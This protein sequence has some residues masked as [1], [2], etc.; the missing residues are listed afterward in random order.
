MATFI[1]Y[2]NIGGQPIKVFGFSGM[3]DYAI[4]PNDEVQ[5]RVGDNETVKDVQYGRVILKGN[6]DEHVLPVAQLKDAALFSTA[7]E[8]SN[9]YTLNRC[10]YLS[11]W[12]AGD[13]T[14]NSYQPESEDAY[15]IGKDEKYHI[16]KGDKITLKLRKNKDTNFF[17][18]REDPISGVCYQVE[19]AA[20]ENAWI[21]VY[22][23][24]EFA[25]PVKNT[26]SDIGDLGI[27]GDFGYTA[28]D[29][30]DGYGTSAML[31]LPQV[32]NKVL[33]T[34]L[35]KIDVAPTAIPINPPLVGSVQKPLD[36][37]VVSPLLPKS[38]FAS[39]LTG[40]GS[41]DGVPTWAKMSYVGGIPLG[42]T[43]AAY[44]D[45]GLLG[46]I[47]WGI[48]GGLAGA[49]PYNHYANI[50]NSTGTYSFSA[51]LPTGTFSMKKT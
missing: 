48:L 27:G 32:E 22:D 44:R 45:S 21:P 31:S 39:S 11:Y 41:A 18:L 24:T 49:L 19:S 35:P 20:G 16:H 40:D 14:F 8:F 15:D 36:V 50:G 12:D 25:T 13:S 51:L 2:K 5:Y 17:E 38:K 43:I 4:M 34:P 1:T 30:T 42:L 28:D 33:D 3:K 47:A 9:V 37:L 46:F 10:Q 29:V 23:L 7:K 26:L 6:A